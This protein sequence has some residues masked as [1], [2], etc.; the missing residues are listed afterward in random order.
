M[1][2]T[3]ARVTLR[4]VAAPLT[5]RVAP[6]GSD[7]DFDPRDLGS[8][9]RLWASASR[10]GGLAHGSPVAAFPDRSGWGTHFQ[11]ATASK[12]PTLV[13]G[14]INGRSA[15]RPDVVDDA[16]DAANSN[17]SQPNTIIVVAKVND[18]AATKR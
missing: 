17:L 2:L 1:A 6:V 18:T 14:A 16:L 13:Q 7:L 4:P 5:S 15:V 10:L 3:N 8:R 12:R 11:Q 9:V